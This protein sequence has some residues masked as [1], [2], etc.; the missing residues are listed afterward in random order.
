MERKN[1]RK[2]RM[3]F[4]A[5]CLRVITFVSLL[6]IAYIFSDSSLVAAQSTVGDS[7]YRYRLIAKIPVPS[8][9]PD[10]A[11][12]QDRLPLLYIALD[13]AQILRVVSAESG[14]LIRDVKIGKIRSNNL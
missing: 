4:D 8:V 2:T 6:V 9:V 5:M 11:F 10:M 7:D 1:V 13:P 3:G 14:E 12:S